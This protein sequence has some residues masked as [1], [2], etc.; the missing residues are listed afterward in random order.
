MSLLARARSLVPLPSESGHPALVAR[1]L[2]A[3]C[4]QNGNV[5]I[6]DLFVVQPISKAS[7]EGGLG[8]DFGSYR[9]SPCW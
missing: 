1:A 2:D 3:G 7:E 8:R 5:S 9:A 4:G 6:N